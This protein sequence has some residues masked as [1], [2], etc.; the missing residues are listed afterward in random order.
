VTPSDYQRVFDAERVN[1][2]PVI[3]AIEA[4][5]GFAIARGRLE[6]AARVL[7]CPVKKHPPNWQHGRVLYSLARAYVFHANGDLT[8]IDVGTAKGFSALCL[9]WA[10]TP[11]DGDGLAHTG[12]V[13]SVDVLDP[14]ERVRRNTVAEVDGYKTLREI[15]QPWPE[16]SGIDFRKSTGAEAIASVDRVHVCYLDGKHAYEAV[17]TE[18][19]L[20]VERQQ[21]GD[22]VIWDDAQI[23]GVSKAISEAKNHYQIERIALLPHRAYAI[24]VRRG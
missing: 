13:V 24:G 19:G 20:L 15:L 11:P 9:E 17:S 23:E 1:E 14:S 12:R 18:I 21:P 7:A 6:G 5:T 10:L 8:L 4:R 22:L 3:D 16:S 2:Y